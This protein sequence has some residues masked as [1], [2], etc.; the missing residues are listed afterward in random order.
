MATGRGCRWQFDARRAED[1]DED[2][3]DPG[4][5]MWRMGGVSSASHR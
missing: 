4:Y 2:E 1:D 3:N 5:I